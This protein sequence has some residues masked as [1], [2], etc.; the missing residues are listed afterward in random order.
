VL[1]VRDTCTTYPEVV[2]KDLSVAGEV[3]IGCSVPI[4][5]VQGSVGRDTGLRQMVIGHII[6]LQGLSSGI[7][8]LQE[9][10]ATR[11]EEVRGER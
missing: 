5:P 6:F 10:V 9:V 7:L 1:V 8:Y 3:V 11:S 4:G 2:A